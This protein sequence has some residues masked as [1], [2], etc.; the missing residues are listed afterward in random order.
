MRT[1]NLR[2]WTKRSHT[3]EIFISAGLSFLFYFIFCNYLSKQ[4]RLPHGGSF[5]NGTSLVSLSWNTPTLETCRKAAAQQGL[6]PWSFEKPPKNN[7]DHDNFRYVKTLNDSKFFN[8]ELVTN[9]IRSCSIDE[10]T[11]KLPTSLIQDLEV[12][13]SR[14]IIKF[15]LNKT[16]QT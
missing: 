11:F 1:L 4:F 6:G 12:F 13:T 7:N 5:R 2:L 15:C 8:Y 10:T 16:W 3:D 14:L 9:K